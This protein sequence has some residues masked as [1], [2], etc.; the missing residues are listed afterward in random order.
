M[1]LLPCGL[2]FAAFARA[3]ATAEPLAGA[4]MALAFGLGTL[5][6][7]LLLGTGLAVVARR[8]RRHSDL[9]AGVVMIAIAGRLLVDGG[10]GL[11]AIAFVIATDCVAGCYNSDLGR[12]GFA[13]LIGRPSWL[14]DE[15]LAH[16]GGL[17]YRPEAFSQKRHRLITPEE[18]V[19]MEWKTPRWFDADDR[20]AQLDEHIDRTDVAHFGI[21]PDADR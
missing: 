14:G 16:S 1:G 7:L 8:Y 19:V 20:S 4:G 18:N 11:V 6:G 3:L 17:C 5:P 13:R 15:M 9:L 12:Q 2:S 21:S 10:A